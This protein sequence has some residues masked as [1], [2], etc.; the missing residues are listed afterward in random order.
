[1]LEIRNI[2]NVQKTTTAKGSAVL[3]FTGVWVS[4][5]GWYPPNKST[6]RVRGKLEAYFKKKPRI[7]LRQINP[8][9][10]PNKSDGAT[11]Q[12]KITWL[13][14]FVFHLFQ[15]RQPIFMVLAKRESVRTDSQFKAVKCC[16]AVKYLIQILFVFLGT[17]PELSTRKKVTCSS[18][19]AAM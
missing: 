17:Q 1:M 10:K 18:E 16:I 12:P 14:F 13:F 19:I 6:D 5:L 11:G 3:C 8:S 4:L 15:R 2:C 9:C 7:S